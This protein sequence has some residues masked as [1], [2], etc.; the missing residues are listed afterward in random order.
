M[1]PDAF[2]ELLKTAA[3]AREMEL[4]ERFQ[5]SLP[6]ADAM[7]DRWDRARRLGF[8][9][10]SSIYESACVFGEVTVGR[11]VWIGPWVMLDGSGGL[12][13]G[14]HVSLSA[15]VQ[16]YT[17]DTVHWALS[18]GVVPPRRAPVAIGDRVYVGSQSVIA[19][20]VTIGRKCVISANSLVIDD[21]PEATIVGGVPAMPIGHVEGEGAEVRLVFTRSPMRR[22]AASPTPTTGEEHA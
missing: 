3:L 5:R 6:F 20:G 15:G 8:G 21:V 11:D 22:A 16:I 7:F 9:E 17:H 4:R 12:S 13:I 19:Q 18:G 1:T 10:G 2:V 14:D